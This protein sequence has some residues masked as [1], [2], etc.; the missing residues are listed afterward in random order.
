MDASERLT[1]IYYRAVACDYDGTLAEGGTIGQTAHAALKKALSSGRKLLLVSGRTISDL[2]RVCPDI[3]LFECVVAENGAVLYWPAERRSAPLCPRLPHS[4]IENLKARNIS[5]LSV[6]EIIAATQEPNETKVLAAIRECG[7]EL[8]VIFNKGSVMIL[9]SGINKATGLKAALKEMRLSPRNVVGIG[10]AENDHEFLQLTGCSVAVANAIPALRA[11]SDFVTSSS[12]G[13]GVAEIV[14]LLVGQDLVTPRALRRNRIPL[15]TTQEDQVVAIEQR[16]IRALIGGVSGSGKS[17]MTTALVQMLIQRDY[18]VCLLDPEGDYESFEEA[19]TFGASQ[20]AP[21]ISEIVRAFD[22]AEQSVIVNLIS[23]PLEDRPAFFSR[24]CPFVERVRDRMGRPHWLVIDEAHHMMPADLPAGSLTCAPIDSIVITTLPHSLHPDS[25][26][27]T[28]L[29]V[30]TS[31]D[32]IAD[33]CRVTGVTPPKLQ[34]PT[35]VDEALVWFRRSEREPTLF[36]PTLASS[37]R[38]RHR[39]KY[40]EGELPSDRSFYF[41]GAEAKLNLRAHNLRRFVDLADGVDE[42]TWIYHLRRCDYSRWVRE[43][44]RDPE[45]ANQIEAVE[46][47]PSLA[48]AD[49][50]AQVRKAI[51]KRYTGGV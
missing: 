34:S 4:F 44:L 46:R 31:G 6:G 1:R 39:R 8:Q 14:D 20:C 47:A 30:A 9:P 36:R 45:L 23:V 5:P 2:Q 17:T 37:P 22:N 51:E 25:L 29:V 42:D 41:R 21:D 16:G 27:A 38:L 26:H 24:L 7:L 15:G 49:S 3:E 18:Q 33:F 40:A 12:D 48:A 35:T 43:A 13:A 11:R 28:D 32:V 10:D 50:R 19:V